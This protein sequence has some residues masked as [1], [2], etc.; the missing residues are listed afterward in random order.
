MVLSA[1]FAPA[2]APWGGA[3]DNDGVYV[4]RFVVR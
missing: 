3:A 2:A 4:A 1:P